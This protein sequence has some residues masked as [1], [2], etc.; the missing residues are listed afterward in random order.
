MVN[1]DRQVAE[2]GPG[3]RV[4]SYIVYAQVQWREPK[5]VQQNV[6]NLINAED[7]FYSIMNNVHSF[8][9]DQAPY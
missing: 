8:A 7:S 4:Y 5:T 3:S 6:P 9:N 2:T 1:D